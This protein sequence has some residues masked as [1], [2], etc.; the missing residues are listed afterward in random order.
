M[1][2]SGRMVDALSASPRL[3]EVYEALDPDRTDLDAYVAMVEEFR[4][5][6]VLD[7]GC[8]TGTLAVTTR[9]GSGRRRGGKDLAVAGRRYTV[10][11][12]RDVRA[13]VRPGQ[14]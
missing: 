6:S 7:L 9:P 12:S 14:T 2:Q 1:N 5:A 4:A 11:G 10:D 3:A 13:A 8:G